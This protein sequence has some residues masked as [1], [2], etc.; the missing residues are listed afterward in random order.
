LAVAVGCFPRW[1]T[2]MGSM[3]TKDADIPGHLLD[4]LNASAKLL[5]SS[6]T[7][8]AAD[9]GRFLNGYLVR[10]E[11]GSEID[12]QTS[13]TWP[14]LSKDSDVLSR[15]ALGEQGFEDRFSFDGVE[16]L[17]QDLPM[18]SLSQYDLSSSEAPPTLSKTVPALLDE[19]FLVECKKLFALFRCCPVCGI[20]I[21]AKAGGYARLYL[22]EGTPTPTVDVACG[23]CW[24]TK[25][26]QRRWKGVSDE[27]AK[28]VAAS[29]GNGAT[30]SVRPK[31]ECSSDSESERPTRA[32]RISS[33]TSPFCD[34]TSSSHVTSEPYGTPG[35]MDDAGIKIHLSVIVRPVIDILEWAPTESLLVPFAPE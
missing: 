4:C 19:I 10:Y 22:D 33:R 1:V 14:P 6:T 3:F 26:T 20:A 17:L 18:A 9:V 5:D 31:R 23:M 28:A 34:E 35:F 29:S 2:D 16:C 12:K 15:N 27:A 21:D 32:E 25:S 11:S 30:N 24:I 8:A 7:L 13:S